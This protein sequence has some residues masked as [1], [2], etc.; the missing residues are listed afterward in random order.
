MSRSKTDYGKLESL[1]KVLEKYAET[2][3]LT[4]KRCS[5]YQWNIEDPSR[6]VIVSVYP[7]SGVAWVPKAEYRNTGLIDKSS[8][9]YIFSDGK[10]MIKILNSLI[11]ARDLT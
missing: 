8:T 11:F 7:G 4:I 6:D 3:M 2:N 5:T 10:S 1:G 9:K